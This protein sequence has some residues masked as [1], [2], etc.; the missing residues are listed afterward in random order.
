MKACVWIAISALILCGCATIKT[1]IQ[2]VAAPSAATP[3]EVES[4]ASLQAKLTTD[5]KQAIADATVAT[6]VMAPVR[7]KC[8]QTILGYVPTL[9]TVNLPE[10]GKSVGLF[11]TIERG[12]EAVESVAVVAE[13][14]I[15]T[16]VRVDLA[17]ACGPVQAR[18]RDL[19]AQWNLRLVN[20]AGTMALLPK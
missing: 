17:V 5:L 15:P 16:Q 1:D 20:V 13:Y 14:Q 18:A 2:A 19:L 7:L 11:D 12:A 6:D 8:W 4:M 10:L 9:P 3:A